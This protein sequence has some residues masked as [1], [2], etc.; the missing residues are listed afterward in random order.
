M[1]E[2]KREEQMENITNNCNRKKNLEHLMAVGMVEEVAGEKKIEDTNNRCKK[3]WV[4]DQI[5]YGKKFRW[6]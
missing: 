6:N 2:I 1:T 3:F 4:V 5:I